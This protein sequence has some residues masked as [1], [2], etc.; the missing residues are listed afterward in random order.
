MEEAAAVTGAKA[1]PADETEE[2][3]I[4]Q[5]VTQPEHGTMEISADRKLLIYTP[6][7]GVVDVVDTFQYTLIDDFGAVS[8]VVTAEVYIEPLIRPYARDDRATTPEDTPK[9]NAKW[10]PAELPATAIQSA[11]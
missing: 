6:D 8:Q 5:I 2:V 1:G 7:V 9:S 4:H 3:F 10:P 11:A